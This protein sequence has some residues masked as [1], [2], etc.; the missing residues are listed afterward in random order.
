MEQPTP[1]TTGSDATPRCRNPAGWPPENHHRDHP[2]RAVSNNKDLILSVQSAG[3][4]NR[5]QHGS[6]RSRFPP[7]LTPPTPLSADRAFG[8]VKPR[9]AKGSERKGFLR[10][11]FISR[12]F[13]NFAVWK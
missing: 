7:N 9:R 4:S 2:T 6:K 1:Q 3:V 8:S 12:K 11:M 13:R 10:M 5:L